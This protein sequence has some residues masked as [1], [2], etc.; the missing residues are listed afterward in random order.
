MKKWIILCLI[1]SIS[2]LSGCSSTDN[3]SED[4]SAVSPATTESKASGEPS[5]QT[6]ASTPEKKLSDSEKLALEYVNVF[7]NGSDLEAKKKFVT[8]NI[9]PDVQPIF[10]LVQSDETT[11]DKKLKNPQVI[12]SKDYTDAKGKTDK[13]VLIQG[14]KSSIPRSELIVLITD[15]KVGWATD[16]SDKE[17]F[18]N[19][20]KVFEE[21]ISDASLITNEPSPESMLNEISNFITSDI[22]NEGFVDISW[23]ISSGTSS[24]GE[25][26]DID[27]TVEQLGKAI[28]KKKEYD[29]YVEGLGPEYDSIKKIWVK[30]SGEIDRMYKQIQENPPKA[31]DKN[32][33]FDTGIFNQ[34]MHAFDKAITDLTKS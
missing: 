3:S 15:N 27:F 17:T 30:L 14:E 32:S 31:N 21:P 9:H 6:T 1:I 34:Y 29:N 4:T 5:D 26:L 2:V 10:Q 11:D 23:Y 25:N 18:N 24:T 13:V 8:D 12:E 33:S 16:P 20:R 28:S 19:I 7:L 22:W